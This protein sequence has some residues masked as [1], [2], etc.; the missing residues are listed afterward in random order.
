MGGA[1]QNNIY[2]AI[3]VPFFEQVDAGEYNI[4]YGVAQAQLVEQDLEAERCD[5]QPYTENGFDIGTLPAGTYTFE[6]YQNSVPSLNNYDLRNRL[7]LTVW[8]TYDVTVYETYHGEYPVI[9]GHQ[10]VDGLNELELSSIH[11]CDSVVHL[12]ASLC[13]LTVQDADDNLYNT[14]VLDRYC[15]TQT[16]MKATHYADANRTPVPRAWVYASGQH[17]DVVQNEATFGRLYTWYSAVN[18]EENS[19]AMPV[20]NAAG[21]VQGICPEGWH[22]PATPEMTALLSHPA[23]D[24]KSTTLWLEPVNN[25]RTGF[26]L[27]PAGKYNASAQRFDDMLTGTHLWKV[28]DPSATDDYNSIYISYH[29][30]DPLFEHA[31]AQNAY[32]VRCVKDYEE[33]NGGE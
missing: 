14:L 4:A 16:N 3:G 2:V 30:S 9:D 20:T 27:L 22:V 32:S 15:W 19:D 29:C 17:P 6:Q 1:T 7:L 10:I 5:N 18:V 23:E 11:G 8:P 25:N 21:F 28:I 24:I 12:Y 31:L 33:W 13:P 26:T